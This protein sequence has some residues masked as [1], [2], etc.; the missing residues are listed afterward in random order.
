MVIDKIL[1]RYD[2]KEYI[3]H[4]FYYDMLAYG[5]DNISRAMDFSDEDGVRRALC[6]YIDNNQYN[7]LIKNFINKTNWLME[8]AATDWSKIIEI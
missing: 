5:A 1:D 6:E 8:E 4:D 7:P 2:G 3:P